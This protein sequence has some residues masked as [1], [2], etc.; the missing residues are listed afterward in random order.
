MRFQPPVFSSFEPAWTL[1]SIIP[2]KILIPQGKNLTK[3]VNSLTHWSVAQ[4]GLNNEKNGLKNLVDCSFK[5]LKIRL[6]KC[7]NVVT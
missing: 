1:R 4:A 3:I 7:R 5:I 2:R 6:E